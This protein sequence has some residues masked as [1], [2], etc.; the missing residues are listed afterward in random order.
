MITSQWER[1]FKKIDDRAP[2]LASQGRARVEV[3]ALSHR[4]EVRAPR[5]RRPDETDQPWHRHRGRIERHRNRRA[6]RVE[7]R[8]ADDRRDGAGEDRR[9]LIADREAGV[10]RRGRKELYE[11]RGHPADDHAV[12]DS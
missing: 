12:T 6:V 3:A 5:L 2:A 11:E 9:E 1:T 8:D 7:Q 10:S 4:G